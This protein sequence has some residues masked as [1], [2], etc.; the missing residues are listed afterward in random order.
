MKWKIFG[1][2]KVCKKVRFE[3]LKY[4]DIFVIETDSGYSVPLIKVFMRYTYDD[5]IYLSNGLSCQLDPR[6]EVYKYCGDI[7]LSASKFNP[8]LDSK[9]LA[10][11]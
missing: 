2:D 6:T 9:L 4:G 3:D 8:P 1:S 7:E 10:K 5:A 11:G